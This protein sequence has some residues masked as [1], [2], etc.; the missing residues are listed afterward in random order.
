MSIFAL[1]DPAALRARVTGHSLW[2]ARYRDGRVI[3]EW[4]CDWSLIPRQGL[5]AA[6]LVCPNGEVAVLGNSVDASDRLFQFKVGVMAAGQKTRREAH[7]IGLL[8]GTN[9]QCKAAAWEYGSGRLVN[10]ED[11][12]FHMRYQ[13]IGCLSAEVLGIKPD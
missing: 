5:V 2:A 1:L 9:G 11:N 10:F 7:I 13:N 6:R 8:T 3:N 4:E 12:V